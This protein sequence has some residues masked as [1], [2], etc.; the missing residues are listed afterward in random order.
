Q[1]SGALRWLAVGVFMNSMASLPFALLQGVGRSDITAKI[2]LAEAPVYVLLMLWLIRQYGIDGAAIA[3]FTRTTVD[4]ALLY[5]YAGRHVGTTEQGSLRD[6]AVLAGLVPS[7]GVGLLFR[8][9]LQKVLLTS[10]LLIL[11]V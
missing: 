3:W 11:F 5:R 10:I 9:P 4:M 1:S 8:S 7:L 2:H 6:L